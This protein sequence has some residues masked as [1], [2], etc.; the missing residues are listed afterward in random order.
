M[1]YAAGD[2][3]IEVLFAVLRANGL[4]QSPQAGY[5][6]LRSSGINPIIKS[7]DVGGK[8]ASAGESCKSYPL[9][10]HLVAG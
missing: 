2:A 5:I 3:V 4:Q 1:V 7:A 10:V 6:A 9:R 8:R